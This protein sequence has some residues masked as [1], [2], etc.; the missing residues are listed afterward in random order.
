MLTLA[1][2]I[3]LLL[4]PVAADAELAALILS[5]EP[6]TETLP[7]TLG[8][9]LERFWLKEELWAGRNYW[10]PE[11]VKAEIEWARQNWPNSFLKLEEIGRLPTAEQAQRNFDAVRA[12]RASLEEAAEFVVFGDAV[13]IQ[14]CELDFCERFASHV[15]R[16][17]DT[18]CQPISRR[19]AVTDARALIGDE[20]FY[21]GDWPTIPWWRIPR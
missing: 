16:A 3:V 17:R 11:V 2:A 6:I 14:R 20:A 10:T 13:Y 8:P 9:A 7:V 21:S 15:L 18:G 19:Q 1:F 4:Q 5:D 12:M